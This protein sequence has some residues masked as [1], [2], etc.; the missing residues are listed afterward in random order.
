LR[1]EN[2]K[3]YQ[4]QGSLHLQSKQLGDQYQNN[5]ESLQKFIKN[6]INK[7]YKQ[8]LSDQNQYSDESIQ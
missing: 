4:N 2:F 7:N 8:I 5:D 1:Q 3:I 6:F